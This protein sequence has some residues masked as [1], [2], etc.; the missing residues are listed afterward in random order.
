M[1]KYHLCADEAVIVQVREH[2]ETLQI[3]DIQHKH[4]THETLK[5]VDTHKTHV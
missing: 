3:V 4:E 1:E 5:I 2:T